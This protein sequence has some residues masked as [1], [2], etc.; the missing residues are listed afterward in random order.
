MSWQDK[1]SN[2]WTR[3]DIENF[4]Y[5]QNY[6]VYDGLLQIYHE[7]KCLLGFSGIDDEKQILRFNRIYDET[8]F[9]EFF[10]DIKESPEVSLK[11]NAIIEETKFNFEDGKAMFE[12]KSKSMVPCFGKYPFDKIDPYYLNFKNIDKL[13][14]NTYCE[15]PDTNWQQK[16][17]YLLTITYKNHIF[18]F[19][20]KTN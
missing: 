4:L 8:V 14:F 10:I 9:K 16:E 1:S 6:T 15:E 5:T 2:L 13:E 17:R 20:D 12:S 19:I 18:F 7:K 3:K 11:L